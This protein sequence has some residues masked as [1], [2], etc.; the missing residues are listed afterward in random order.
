[1]GDEE[2]EE[3][4]EEEEE[5]PKEPEA[6]RRFEA[7]KLVK[8]LLYVAGGILLIVLVTGIGRISLRHR[9]P[10]PWPVSSCLIFRRPRPMLSR[11]L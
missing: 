10:R 11:I 3:I 9:R 5:T 1:M 7:S 4:I 6:G 8:I 2:K